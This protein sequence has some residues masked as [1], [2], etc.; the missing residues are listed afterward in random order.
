MFLSLN[1]LLDCVCIF[2]K[3]FLCPQNTKETN[4]NQTNMKK[5]KLLRIAFVAVA[6]M[7]SA[8]VYAEN[9]P[10]KYID[11]DGQEKYVTDYTILTGEE[12]GLQDGWYVVDKKDF[13]SKNYLRIMGDVHII[14]C[15]NV[16]WTSQIQ[17]PGAFFDSSMNLKDESSLSIYAQSTG[18]A[19]GRFH[20][21]NAGYSYNMLFCQLNSL[22]IN[23]GSFVFED[24]PENAVVIFARNFVMNGGKISIS[25]AY[26][27]IESR[28][29][30]LNGGEINVTASSLGIGVARDL[31][32]GKSYCDFVCKCSSF[33]YYGDNDIRLS[34]YV[35]VTLDDKEY[36]GSVPY[37][38]TDKVNIT[39][40]TSHYDDGTTTAVEGMNVSRE[41][42]DMWYTITGVRLASKPME[43]GVYIFNGTKICVK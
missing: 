14:M 18:D 17:S 40:I 9:E 42:S 38:I 27:G 39:N 23:G 11:A 22:V 30:C 8:S 13:V 33:G 12:V 10:V 6:S 26:K 24:L 21:L 32:F 25:D 5:K 31:T 35:H 15:D 16:V 29:L 36:L 20:N 37:D 7:L 3:F 41:E 43:R 1:G 34:D 4:Y 28:T 19:M 2:P